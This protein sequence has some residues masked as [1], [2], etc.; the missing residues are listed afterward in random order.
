LIIK[1]IACFKKYVKYIKR[2]DSGIEMKD[3][4]TV[5]VDLDELRNKNMQM[6]EEVE[7]PT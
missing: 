1:A 3:I 4:G 5:E 2:M 7:M 6:G